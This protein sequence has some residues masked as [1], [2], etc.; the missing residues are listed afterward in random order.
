LPGYHFLSIGF[1]EIRIGLIQAQK[2]ETS[3]HT[4][5]EQ[6]STGFMKLRITLPFKAHTKPFPQYNT[7]H[8]P[9]ELFIV[10]LLQAGTKPISEE[11]LRG[12][13]HLLL[14]LPLALETYPEPLP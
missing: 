2:I 10:L 4:I 1:G 6:Q 11:Q 8:V 9:P 14:T 12:T 7:S 13:T 3:M 5:V